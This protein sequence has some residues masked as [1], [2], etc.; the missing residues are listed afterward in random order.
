[1]KNILI[2]IFFWATFWL[3]VFT[4]E[5]I[6]RMQF[7]AWELTGGVYRDAPTI[8]LPLSLVLSLLLFWLLPKLKWR[9]FMMVV[10]GVFYFLFYTYMCTQV[11]WD[12]R[13]NYGNT[14]LWNEV[15]FELVA[16][17]W[18]FYVL[19][20]MG[21]FFFQLWLARIRNCRM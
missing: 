19:G 12:Y 17:H 13:V 4:F 1:M 8:Y 2:F 14:W 16:V 15:F 5:E 9:V 20:V 11:A 6:Y 10:L 18:Y 7:S 3:P 21:C